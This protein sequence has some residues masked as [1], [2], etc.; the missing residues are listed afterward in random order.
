MGLSKIHSGAV[1]GIEA[2]P[3]EIEVDVSTSGDP[4]IFTVGLP[5]TAVRESSTRVVAAIDNSGFAPFIGV[6]TIN[7]APADIKK[8]GPLFD[9]PIAMGI[10]VSSGQ[11]SLESDYLETTGMVGEL[12]LSGEVR[13]VRGVLPIAL[14]M[15]RIGMKRL[16]VPRENAEEAAVVKGLEV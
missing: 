11:V 15:K 7:L 9:L 12:A 2:F 14:A 10:L 4:K 5:D 3:V 16:F 8:E 1:L 13:R 6:T